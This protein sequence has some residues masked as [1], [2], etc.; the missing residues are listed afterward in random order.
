MR[1]HGHG[2]THPGRF[3]DFGGRYA[4]ESQIG[5]LQDL[6][7]VF[8]HATCDAHFW[9]EFWELV[10][11]PPPPAYPPTVCGRA[12]ACRRRGCYLA[13]AGGSSHLR[14]PQ[15]IQPRRTSVAGPAEPNVDVMRSAATGKHLLPRDGS[16]RLLEFGFAASPLRKRQSAAAVLLR[17]LVDLTPGL[18]Q[19]FEIGCNKAARLGATLAEIH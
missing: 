11:P 8:C 14:G 12:D 19:E 5:F 15:R 4:A 2:S 6:T 17:P 3:G 7:A 10:P 13:E 9:S 1:T 16:I 18:P